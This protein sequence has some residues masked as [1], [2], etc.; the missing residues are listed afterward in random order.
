MN[1]VA[2]VWRHPV[3]SL[4]GERLDGA[5][6]GPAGLEGDRRWAVFA[7]GREALTARQ[8]H[9]LLA[10]AAR[11]DA[12]ELVIT[13]PDGSEVRPGPERDARLSAWLGYPVR[14]GSAPAAE[15]FV[16]D[17]PVHLVSAASAGEW[18]VRRFRPTLAL[19]GGGEQGWE[20]SQVEVGE[21]VLAV[22]KPMVRCVMTTL[23]QPGL[24]TD[25][26]VLR[27]IVRQ[28]GGVLGVKARVVRPGY[29]SVGD[30]VSV[31]RSA[32]RLMP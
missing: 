25:R 23:A 30:A 26:D 8:E 16:D 13:L 15:P 5:L 9:R 29:V 20:G 2:A 1:T 28:R 21:A 12:G 10:A 31:R 32:S 22:D 3:K 17:S 14:L 18:D 19:D 6:L 27:A 7:G 11:W 24:P 4:Q